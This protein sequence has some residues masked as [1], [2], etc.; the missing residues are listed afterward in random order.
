MDY[1]IIGQ[2]IV[3]SPFIVHYYSSPV[4]K[5]TTTIT[6][7][8][9]KTSHSL[10]IVGSSSSVQRHPLYILSSWIWLPNRHVS[11][12]LSTES[13]DR[14]IVRPVVRVK[15]GQECCFADLRKSMSSSTIWTDIIVHSEYRYPCYFESDIRRSLIWLFFII[16][17]HGRGENQFQEAAV[18]V[19]SRYTLKSTYQ[20]YVRSV[21]IMPGDIQHDRWM[22][23]EGKKW[24][25]EFAPSVEL[26]TSSSSSSPSPS[27]IWY[28]ILIFW[29]TEGIKRRADKYWIS[30]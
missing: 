18:G 14:D 16:T 28:F 8:S 21:I 11:F 6:S 25:D 19:V 24:M 1:I 15:F 13:R 4:F 2:S 30:F 17:R 9:A 12:P 23:D 27:D 10:S 5:R 26:T 29:L 7:L 22:A 3:R 20:L